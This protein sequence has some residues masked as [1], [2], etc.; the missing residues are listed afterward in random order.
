M[1]KIRHKLG[2]IERKI[3]LIDLTYICIVYMQPSKRLVSALA[4]GIGLLDLHQNNVII[5]QLLH[6]KVII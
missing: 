6:V 3:V 2:G 4:I 1:H 5:L